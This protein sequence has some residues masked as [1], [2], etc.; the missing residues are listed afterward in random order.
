MQ[1]NA[2]PEF[3]ERRHTQLT[4]DDLW[5]RLSLSQQFSTTSLNQYGYELAFIRGTQEGPLAILLCNGKAATVNSHGEIDTAPAI[6]I[7]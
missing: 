4:S 1:P 3:V 2:T 6:H 5:G 7:R